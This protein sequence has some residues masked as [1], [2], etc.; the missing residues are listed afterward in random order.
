M[1]YSYAAVPLVCRV[2]DRLQ[3]RWAH[4]MFFMLVLNLSHVLFMMWYVV[5]GVTMYVYSIFFLYLNT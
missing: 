2:L 4:G 5:L 3:L 1:V